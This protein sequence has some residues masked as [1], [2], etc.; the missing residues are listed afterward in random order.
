MSE[1][2]YKDNRFVSFDP[3]T[4]TVDKPDK[5]FESKG[6]Q[7]L[8][9]DLINISQNS[10]FKVIKNGLQPRKVLGK[11]KNVMTFCCSLCH[12]YKGDIEKKKNLEYRILSYRNDRKNSRGK[13]GKNGPRR[14]RSSLPLQSGNTCRYT[15]FVSV[16]PGP[17][18]RFFICSGIGN[19]YHKDHEKELPK[20]KGTSTRLLCEN[21]KEEISLMKDCHVSPTTISN[22]IQA[23]SG[24]RLSRQK[25]E[26][27]SKTRELI[28]K[29]KNSNLN[30]ID[31]IL[32]YFKTNDVDYI[33]LYHEDQLSDSNTLT[34]EVY[35][36]GETKKNS[37][38]QI[39]VR[40]NNQYCQL[41]FPDWPKEDL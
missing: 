2:K 19:I 6:F 25:V 33:I 39:C 9:H 35:C 41:E 37:F 1:T 30:S 22:I 21:S 17:L 12:K 5:P 26:Y 11:T 14:R 36:N 7:D 10:G 38:T 8:S 3:K 31:K 24:A 18:S 40:G 34:N 13:I 16:L 15:F 27:V 20:N 23:K 4:Y 32:H 29:Y 28:E